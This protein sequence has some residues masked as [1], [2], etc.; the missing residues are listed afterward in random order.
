MPPQPP[1]TTPGGG[2]STQGPTTDDP[3]N[4][5]GHNNH[6]VDR[7]LRSIW[8][9]MVNTNIVSVVIIFLLCLVV[10]LVGELSYLNR[11]Y[12]HF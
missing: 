8:Y 11:L 10:I 9:S 3:G 2:E 5:G 4:G 7:M 12:Q 6:D 1:V